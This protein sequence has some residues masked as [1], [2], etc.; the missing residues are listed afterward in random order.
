MKK[1]YV[2]WILSVCMV[3]T[4]SVPILS[5]AAT[6]DSVKVED[7]TTQSATTGS[8]IAP[9]E[10]TQP[11]IKLEKV[12]LS[13]DDA[14]KK[15]EGSKTMEVIKLQKQTDQSVAKGYSET[16]S[17]F[18][19][20]E[21][22]DAIIAGYDSSNKLVAQE[23]RDFA[24]LM[25]ESNNQARV[26][27]MKQEAFQKYYTLKNTETQ[28]G[29][30][31]E[32][33]QLKKDFL[34]TTKRK[35][36]VGIVSKSDVDNA[37]KDKKDAQTQL[38]ATQNSLQ[39]LRLSFNSYLGYDISQEVVLTDQIQE[40]ELPKTSL[41]DA[42]ASALKN[43]IEMK[44]VAYNVKISQLNLN[45]YKAYPSSSSK[46]IS[47]KT[48]LLNAEIANQNKPTDIELDVRKKYD[49]M[50]DAYN[51]VQTGKGTL[52]RAEDTLNTTNRKYNLGMVTIS[53]VQQAQLALNNAKLNQANA[54]L[55]FKLAVETYNLSMGV[56]TVAA[57]L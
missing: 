27:A 24:N 31:K 50:M 13:L 23:R 26:N 46:Y 49:S 51:S 45:S 30:A 3:S 32:S 11:A 44:E 29:I 53:D 6:T 5:S 37:E 15:L 10:T 38:E 21:K 40:I 19:K 25:L 55:S 48:L 9:V 17:S 1:K 14:Y 34:E 22:S 12:N 52:K 7:L 36:K 4:M 18:S 8:A 2:M 56:G 28:V 41:T 47:A 57:N 16:A 54:L 42:I 20:M 39:Q 43:R 35:Y 33:L